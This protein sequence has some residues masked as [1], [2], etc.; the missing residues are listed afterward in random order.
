MSTQMIFDYVIVGAGSAGCVLANRLSADEQHRVCLLEAGPRDR[1]PLISIPLGIGQLLPGTGYNLHQYTAP[2][3]HLN[4]RRLFWPRGRT[5]GGS[6]AINAMV[7]IR[8]NSDDY[9]AWESA[10]NPGWGW[11][12]LLP[13]FLLA[14]GNERGTDAYHSGYGP[15]SVSDLKWKTKSGQA[16]VRAAQASGHRLNSDFN[17]SQQNGV[18]FYQVT[19][20]RGRRCSAAAAYLHPVAN[21]PN[22][23]VR[24]NSQVARVIFRGEKATGVELLNGTKI[25]ANKEVILSAGAIQ[26]PHLLLL[27]GVGHE[28]ALRNM[29]LM[30]Q[31]HL[32]GVGKNLQ[33]HLDIIQVVKASAAVSFSESLWP[34]ALTALRLPELIF[35]NRGPLSS[36]V[37]EAGGFASSSLAGGNPDIQFHMTA[38]P[39]FQHGFE[40][41]PGYGY[42]LHACALRPKSRGEITLDSTDPR[43]LPRI[44]PNYLSEPEDLEVLVEAYEMARDILAQEELSRY[45]KRHWLPEQK[46]TDRDSIIH[47][48]RQH[49]ESIYHP[50]G[51]C[52]M[53]NDDLAVV[54][55]ELKVHG[56]DGL[57][58]V[59]ASIMP[60]LISGNTNAPVI[61]IAEK[62][63]DLILQRSPR[64]FVKENR[65]TQEVE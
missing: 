4:E 60:T 34:K 41:R 14:E 51:T 27:S 38:S 19:Q 1:S 28:G 36:N 50:V 12:D 53:G 62:A 29:G 63:A 44:E 6:S 32:P 9:D 42:S 25:L 37:A 58:V 55:N 3:R 49:A 24:T 57:R 17:G 22:L 45:Q 15:L 10:G 59:D 35:L 7:Y 26:S 47:Y 61:A 40:K 2:Q 65:H 21:R 8:G 56:V 16:F 46:L 33:D 39:I 43:V 30:P 18:G 5:L 52:R 11:Q 48:I 31:N 20:R 23:F 54:D 64:S 13:Y